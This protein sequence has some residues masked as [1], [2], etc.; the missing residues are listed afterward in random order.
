MMTLDERAREASQA[1]T[2][3]VAE[4]APRE[5]FDD[6]MIRH[7]RTRTAGYAVAG[8]L[9]VAVVL[10]GAWLRGPVPE[11]DVAVTTTTPVVE[12]VEPSID[13]ALPVVPVVPTVPVPDRSEIVEPTVEPT[14]VEPTPAAAGR[15]FRCRGSGTVPWWRRRSSRSPARPNPGR[16]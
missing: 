8:G 4:Y 1:I 15:R 5:T 7:R 2:S 6:V 10:V 12:E 14:P 13:E 11:P 16:S 9:A 3:S